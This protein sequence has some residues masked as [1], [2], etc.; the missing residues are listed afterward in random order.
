MCVQGQRLGRSLLDNPNAGMFMTVDPSLMPLGYAKPSLQIEIVPNLIHFISAHKEAGLEAAHHLGHVFVEWITGTDEAFDQSSKVSLTRA[1]PPFSGSRVSATCWIS[2]TC[3]R[4]TSC[5]DLTELKPLSMQLA[6]RPSCSSASPF[7]RVHV[8]LDR[9]PYLG[10]RL[11]HPQTRRLKRSSLIVV[12]DAP[13][14]GAIGQNHVASRF[15][16][17]KRR[18]VKVSRLDHDRGL[19]Q[20][21]RFCFS[22]PAPLLQDRLFNAPE[23]THFRPHL[24]LGMAVG[25][26]DRLGQVPQEVIIAIAVRHPGN[27]TAIPFTKASCLSDIQRTTRLPSFSAHCFA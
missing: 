22:H 6:K 17:G 18:I 8:S 13:H 21:L 12:E 24:D 3:F 14:R 1:L 23:A 11:G 4:S 19:R 15:S 5:S 10:E 7:F 2:S 16:L 26:Q 20:C 9:L 25:F 27:S